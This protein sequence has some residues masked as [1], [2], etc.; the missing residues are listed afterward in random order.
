VTI[1]S[2]AQDQ[3]YPNEADV[4]G[5]FFNDHSSPADYSIEV[6]VLQNGQSV[7][8]AIPGGP[9]SDTNNVPPFGHATW[10]AT[11]KPMPPGPVTCKIK[12]VQRHDDGSPS[13]HLTYPTSDVSLSDCTNDPTGVSGPSATVNVYNNHFST[14]TYVVNVAF[15]Q[16]GKTFAIATDADPRLSYVEAYDHVTTGATSYQTA[17]S[18]ATIT[19]SLAGVYRW[20]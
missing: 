11:L 10:N 19:C 9:L 6:E 2:C 7:G 12:S 20:G 16:G 4:T 3:V 5:T 14:G 18:G 13:G 8:T 17:P 15:S 1:T